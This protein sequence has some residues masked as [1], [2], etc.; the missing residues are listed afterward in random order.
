MS[1]RITESMLNNKI[2]TINM[3]MNTP[4]KHYAE[5][6]KANV[7]HYYLSYQYGGVALYQV[8][9][10]GDRSV[11]SHGFVTKVAMYDMLSAF[12]RGIQEAKEAFPGGVSVWND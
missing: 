3:H 2:V 11:F 7:G 1:I 12:I 8:G 4:D 5:P 10:N 6:G 9:K